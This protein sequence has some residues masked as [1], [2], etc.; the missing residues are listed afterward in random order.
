L[1][2]INKRVSSRNSLLCND[3]QLQIH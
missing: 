2:S 1:T 3:F